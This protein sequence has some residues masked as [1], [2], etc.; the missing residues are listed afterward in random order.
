MQVGMREEHENVE[1]VNTVGKWKGEEIQIEVCKLVVHRRRQIGSGSLVVRLSESKANSLHS[2]YCHLPFA[3]CTGQPTSKPLYWRWKEVRALQG[4]QVTNK[5]HWDRGGWTS[6]DDT[7]MSHDI[8]RRIIA[9]F[10][11]S[12]M[13][14]I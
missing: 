14:K 13:I 4:L 6:Y 12:H 1:E 3:Y 5:P 8:Y 2:Y 7:Q 11:I 10:Y 9:I